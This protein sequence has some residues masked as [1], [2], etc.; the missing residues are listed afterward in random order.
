MGGAR[1]PAGPP[2]AIRRCRPS[3]SPRSRWSRRR[4]DP[5]AQSRRVD[6]S[7]DRARPIVRGAGGGT[8][9]LLQ[10]SRRG[11]DG[12]FGL[13]DAGRCAPPERPPAC[14]D[15]EP[16]GLR[17]ERLRSAP[18][19]A[20]SGRSRS[21]DSRGTPAG[22]ACSWSS[23]C[24]TERYRWF[25]ELNGRPV[26]QPRAVAARW[27]EYPR[28]RWLALS[29]LPAPLPEPPPFAGHAVP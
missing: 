22:A 26:G 2:P 19:G 27:L 8:P 5:P 28:G 11:R 4:P 9:V 25:I 6:S 21:G 23:C 16:L 7:A 24:A 3:S 10:R 14:A 20:G 29:I 1:R 15:D 18:V 17:L 12:V 13:A